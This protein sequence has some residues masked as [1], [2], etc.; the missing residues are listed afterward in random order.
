MK[1]L[2]TV[3]ALT[4]ATMLAACNDNLRSTLVQTCD[5]LAV[6][7]AHYDAVEATGAVSASTVRKVALARRQTDRVCDNPASATTISV[8]AAA[9]SA[10]IA[11]NA[12]FREGG[13]M[14]SAQM[15]Y[16]KITD[17]KRIADAVRKQN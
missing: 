13:E 12:A 14:R 7:Y 1:T 15:G 11:L 4:S 16:S 2:F 17:L 5:G 8:T 10:Y 6:A 3:L 9:S